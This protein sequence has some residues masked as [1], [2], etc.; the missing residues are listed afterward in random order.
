ML[1]IEIKK[2]MLYMTTDDREEILALIPYLV[3]AYEQMRDR[4]NNQTT[5]YEGIEIKN[6]ELPKP[7]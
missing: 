6:Y 4:G 7:A 2:N 3:K 5:K 1:L